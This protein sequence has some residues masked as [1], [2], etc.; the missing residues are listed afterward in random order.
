MFLILAIFTFFLCVVSQ[1]VS[2]YLGVSNP[3]EGFVG[4][5]ADGLLISY[6]PNTIQ[7]FGGFKSLYLSVLIVYPLHRTLTYLKS[8]LLE[9]PVEI[10]FNAYRAPIGF[11]YKISTVVLKNKRFVHLLSNFLDTLIFLNLF[12][13]PIVLVVTSFASL[14]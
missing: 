1:V 9:P 4:P 8:R 2:S 12:I 10:D 6:V 7:W 11:I 3:A 13:G 5:T 14:I